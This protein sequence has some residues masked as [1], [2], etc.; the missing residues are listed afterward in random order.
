[1]IRRRLCASSS[2]R[3]GISFRSLSDDV[4]I[5]D[6][7]KT[8]SDIS[9]QLRE[10]RRERGLTLSQLA[11]R[12]NTSSAT[13][14]RYENGWARFELY[15]LRKLATALG[16][17]LKITLEPIVTPRSRPSRS[18]V[19]EQLGRLFWDSQLM[20]EH[21][22][23]HTVWVIERTLEYGSLDDVRLLAC[24]LGREEFLNCVSE[25]RFSSARTQAFWKQILEREGRKCT[26]RFSRDQAA[27]SWLD[28]NS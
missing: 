27:T 11:R 16:C 21:L 1:M 6:K 8:A 28:S 20:P 15:T 26:R 17:R 10:R 2:L 12:A 23:A 24:W 4:I 13:L 18:Q 25:A 7:M 14:S 22:Q 3:R 19:V 5:H 9:L